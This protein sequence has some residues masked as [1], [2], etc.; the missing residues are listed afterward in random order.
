MSIGTLT[1]TDLRLRTAVVQQLDWEPDVDA[2]AIGVA[3]AKGVVTLT[4]FIDTYAGKL[5]AERA[6]KRVRG[7]RA[8]ANDL[9][10]RL[11]LE[12]TDPEIA[13]DAALALEFRASLADRIQAVVHS[14]HITLTGTVN[15]LGRKREAASAVRHIPGVR[16]VIN[17][18]VVEAAPTPFDVQ[19]RIV[20]AMQ[21]DADLDARNV[22]V[23]VAGRTVTLT[24]SVRTWR[25]REA[26]ERAAAN[27]VGIRMVDN[28]LSVDPFDEFP[29]GA[30]DEVC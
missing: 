13:A 30:M 11:R 28:Q 23:S 22:I 15:W 3:A 19:R 18:I 2:S 10:V 7:V 1:D 9:E 12:R 17:H 21:R 5:A 24:G 27:A 26:A 14:G 8:V 29:E 6:A 16:G 25:Q 4:G 20:Q